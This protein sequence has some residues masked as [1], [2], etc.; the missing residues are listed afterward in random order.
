MACSGSVSLELLYH[1]RPAVILYQ[2]SRFGYF[3]QSLFRKVRYITLVNL[4]TAEDPFAEQAAGIYHP[5]DPRDAHVLLPEYLT[6]ED[7]SAELAEHIVTWL[8]DETKYAAVENSLARLK[9]RVGQGG[10]SQRAA[11]YI[12]GLVEQSPK[13]RSTNEQLQRRSA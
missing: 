5:E 6:C 2:I 4:L 13:A 9:Q 7:R 3:V 1:N 11:E 8:I 10:A 12:T